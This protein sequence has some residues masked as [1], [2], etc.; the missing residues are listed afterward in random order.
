MKELIE[1]ATRKMA[2]EKDM[3]YRLSLAL[4]T[5]LSSIRDE[6]GNIPQKIDV[7]IQLRAELGIELVD[8]V[9]IGVTV[10]I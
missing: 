6:Y 9:F 1:L 7:D 3:A 2:V 5:E 4:E 8:Y 10:E